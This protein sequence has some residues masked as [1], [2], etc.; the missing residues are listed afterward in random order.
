MLYMWEGA[1][2]YRVAALHGA[3]PRLA[4]ERRAGT[5]IR[6]APGSILGRI[7]QMK[8]T[9]HIADV[10]AEKIDVPQGFTPSGIAIYGG[11]RTALVAPMLKNDELVGAIAIYRTEVRPFTDKQVELVQNFATQAVI[12]I[13]NP[14]L[15]NEL[16]ESLEQ[17]TATSEVLRV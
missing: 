2:Q 16:R 12:A 13:K 9:V 11:A 7:A 4:E 5:V 10:L 14:R 6:S 3:P 8:H 17:Q 1:G 15:L